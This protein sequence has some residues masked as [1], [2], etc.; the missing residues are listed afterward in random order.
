MARI[1]KIRL[2]SHDN[3]INKSTS[4]FPFFYDSSFFINTSNA[5]TR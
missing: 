5:S 2:G 4:F 3:S 1:D